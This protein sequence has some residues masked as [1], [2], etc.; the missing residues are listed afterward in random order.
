MAKQKK[1]N[2]LKNLINETG[3]GLQELSKSLLGSDI[4]VIDVLMVLEDAKFSK[5]RI[6][7][8]AQLEKHLFKLLDLQ[9]D[10]VEQKPK[11]KSNPFRVKVSVD[12]AGE[13]GIITRLA[14]GITPAKATSLIGLLQ[15]LKTDIYKDGLLLLLVG[16]EKE[17]EEVLVEALKRIC[18]K[19]DV[20]YQYTHLTQ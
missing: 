5:R 9:F 1:K 12:V 8:Q 11:F 7:T 20:A 17:E 16:S 14:A 13:L 6:K 4:S 15:V 10:G 3:K 18:E 19:M 2:F